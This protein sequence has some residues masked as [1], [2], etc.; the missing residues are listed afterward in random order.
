MNE[1]EQH[2]FFDAMKDKG[3]IKGTVAVSKCGHDRGRIYVVFSEHE[4][5]LN[6]CEGDK[7][8]PENPKKKRRN[9]VC[10]LG[11][12]QNAG[13]WIDSLKTLPTEVQNS[14]IRKKIRTFLDR[15]MDM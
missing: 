14:E 12:I 4:S 11:Q 6:L 2:S 13:E 3:I 7:R 8:S 5:F 9:H 10:P 15:H 1:T